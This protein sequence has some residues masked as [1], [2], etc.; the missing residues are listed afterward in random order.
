MRTFFMF[1]VLILLL[2]IV[3]FG[4]GVNR[5]LGRSIFSAFQLADLARNNGPRTR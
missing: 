3:L 2:V 1:Y 4:I 5:G